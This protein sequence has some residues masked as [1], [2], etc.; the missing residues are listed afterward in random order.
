MVRLLGRDLANNK[1]IKY[2]LTTIY[3]IGLSRSKEILES[4][5]LHTA[6][7]KGIRV[8]DL[9]DEEISS[10]RKILEKNYQL[11]GDLL[12]LTNLNIKRL[13]EN[14]SIK[15]RRHRAGLPV[16]GQRTRTNARTRR[17][18]KKTVAGKKK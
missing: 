6:E 7:K 16:R 18:G 1:K 8:K 13:M 14:G 12:R 15:G 4:A 3:G 2:A 11:E 17:G 5:G 10:L 9:S